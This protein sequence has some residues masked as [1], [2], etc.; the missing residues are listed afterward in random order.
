[1]LPFDRPNV[2]ARWRFGWLTVIWP[3]G[4]RGV[5]CS[6]QAALFCLEHEKGLRIR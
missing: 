2:I 5:F 1:M 4:W 6:W 3:D